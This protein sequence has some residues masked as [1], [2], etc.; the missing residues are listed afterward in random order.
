MKN[1]FMIPFCLLFI[2]C[3]FLIYQIIIGNTQIKEL[4]TEIK[5]LEYKLKICEIG[6]TVYENFARKC[7]DDVEELEEKL[8]KIKEI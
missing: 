2:V 3:C 8:K 7:M 4:K 1:K 5:G 6:S